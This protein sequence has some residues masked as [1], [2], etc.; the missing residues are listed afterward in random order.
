MA[1]KFNE[2]TGESRPTGTERSF[3]TIYNSW[4]ALMTRKTPAAIQ[5][6]PPRHRYIFVE[7][8]TGIDLE[9]AALKQN[10]PP[11]ISMVPRP[12]RNL[13]SLIK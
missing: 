1:M 10:I 3:E 6:V 2:D 8:F 4:K 13:R 9:N 12:A 11:I 7:L 5:T